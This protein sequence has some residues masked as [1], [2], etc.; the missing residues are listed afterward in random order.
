MTEN[1]ETAGGKASMIKVGGGDFENTIITVLKVD[2]AGKDA[3]KKKE[4]AT[5][6]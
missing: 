3:G 4:E 6:S 2:N 1:W 5:S